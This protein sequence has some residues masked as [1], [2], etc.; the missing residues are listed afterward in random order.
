MKLAFKADS[1]TDEVTADEVIEV[2]IFGAED[3]PLIDI[4]VERNQDGV[5]GSYTVIARAHDLVSIY[6]ASM[7]EGKEQHEEEETEECNTDSKCPDCM[8]SR[9]EKS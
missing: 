4:H 9:E 3:K 5:G 6:P 8:E 1:K 7:D 2:R